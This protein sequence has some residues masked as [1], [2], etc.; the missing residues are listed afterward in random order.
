MEGVGRGV[1]LEFGCGPGLHLLALAG[2]FD[3]SIG[4]DL[5][6]EMIRVARER[7]TAS[8]WA[9]R[10]SLRVDPAETLATVEDAS[11]DVALCVGAMEHMLDPP[12]VLHQVH[13]VLR[14]G[15]RLVCLTPNGGNWWYRRAAPLFRLDTRHLSTDRFLTSNELAAM[16]RAAGLDVLSLGWWHF[17]PRGDMPGW[18]S[19]AFVVGERLGERLGVGWLRGGIALA[20]ERQP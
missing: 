10:V 9:E 14:R 2:E 11:V 8:A 12:A 20:A 19:A 7:A 4:T 17:V 3:A 6:P 18:A 1:L 16:V 15:G 5:S 13:R